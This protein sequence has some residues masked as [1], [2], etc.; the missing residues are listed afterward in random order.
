MKKKN[1]SYGGAKHV[2]KHSGKWHQLQKMSI[3]T[4]HIK[5]YHVPAWMA[6]MEKRQGKRME[7]IDA[8]KEAH[9]I[10]PYYCGG[11]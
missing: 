8:W 5:R 10:H 3:E 9:E 11:N 4:M 1:V 6:K 2:K 7:R